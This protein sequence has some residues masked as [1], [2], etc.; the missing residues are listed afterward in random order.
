MVTVVEVNYEDIC[1]VETL[2]MAWEQIK[3]KG[4]PDSLLVDVFEN[5]DYEF[6]LNRNLGVISRR[7]R[8]RRY[9]P[10]PV[11]HIPTTKGGGLTRPVVTLSLDDAIVS[12]AIIYKLAPYLDK[13]LISGV[14]SMRATG[15]AKKPFRGWY[16]DWP[17]YQKKLQGMLD[18]SWLVISDITGYF[19]NIDLRILKEQLLRLEHVDSDIVD[20]V[21]FVLESWMFRQ[22]YGMP[23]G[24][25]IPQADL[26][27]PQ[28]LSNFFLYEHDRRMDKFTDGKYIRWVDDMNIVVGS[29]LEGKRVIREL[30][31]SLKFQ[32]LTPN[33]SKTRILGPE[34]ILDYFL[35]EEND[36][37]TEFESRLKTHQKSKQPTAGL[38]EELVDRFRCFTNRKRDGS[39]EK[40]LKRYYTAFK[41]LNSHF[42]ID[43]VSEDLLT[44]PS[45]DSKIRQYMLRIDFQP[46]MVD[47]V[48]GYLNSE[49][50]MYPSTES[51]LVR[52]LMDLRIPTDTSTGPITELASRLLFGDGAQSWYIRCLAAMLIAKYG[53]MSDTRKIAAYLADS[54]DN[55][56]EGDLR[57]HLLAV[58]LLLPATDSDFNRAMLYS[59]GQEDTALSRVVHFYDE[60]LKWD[61]LPQ[62][63]KSRLTLKKLEAP[64]RKFLGMGTFLLLRL[65][66][67]NSRLHSDLRGPVRKIAKEN[68]DPQMTGKIEDLAREIA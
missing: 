22:L 34:E 25:G 10:R 62:L 23:I 60:A 46:D 39:W 11:R 41:R 44:R 18:D 58:S 17:K 43:R 3:A 7:L 37:L 28:A 12:Q 32:F 65:L 45:M 63:V 15:K 64:K 56:D 49:Q 2:R 57:R 13:R 66:C 6:D 30:E 47:I 14:F 53:V 29:E 1:S 24:R 59:R 50:N 27:F 36:Y 51:Q 21:L 31:E 67:W 54:G 4:G 16:R 55:L 40:V 26:D 52:L 68:E 42:L 48:V 9:R 61:S 5:I 8:T 19:D 20:L 35:F 38:E 33:S